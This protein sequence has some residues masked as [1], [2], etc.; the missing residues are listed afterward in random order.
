MP[1][2]NIESAASSPNSCPKGSRFDY[3]RQQHF[4]A[5]QRKDNARPNHFSGLFFGNFRGCPHRQP[6]DHDRSLPPGQCIRCAEAQQR[7]DMAHCGTLFVELMEAVKVVEISDQQMFGFTV[8]AKSNPSRHDLPWIENVYPRTPSAS[9]LMTREKIFS[10]NGRSAAGLSARD[11]KLLVQASK[12]KL[13]L[14]VFGEMED[15]SRLRSEILCRGRLGCLLELAESWCKKVDNSSCDFNVK[16][17]QVYREIQNALK[18]F[19]SL[20]EVHDEPQDIIE[21]LR[22]KASLCRGDPCQ[23]SKFYVTTFCVSIHLWRDKSFT[24]AAAQAWS[25]PSSS[26]S[27]SSSASA[28]PA[29]SSQTPP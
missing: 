27:N 19:I 17:A 12:L 14:E 28:A 29:T 21:E 1:A 16:A 11:V 25:T 20:L 8:G 2:T 7:R 24:A 22:Q 13:H 6:I 26:P 9:K 15:E 23:P 3:L 18:T 5:L 4:V 10:I